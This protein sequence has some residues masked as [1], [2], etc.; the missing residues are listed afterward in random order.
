MER[1]YKKGFRV[2]R[3]RMRR[4]RKLNMRRLDD[5]KWELSVILREVAEENVGAIRG[6][7]YT[8]A[9]KIGVKEAKQFIR[10]KEEEGL[11]TSETARKLTGLLTKYSVFR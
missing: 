8:K 1:S 2:R 4:I 11:I 10:E 7:I 6:A 3:P 5:F 9:S